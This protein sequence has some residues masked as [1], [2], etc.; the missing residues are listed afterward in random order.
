LPLAIIAWLSPETPASPLIEALAPDA[1]HVVRGP[2]ARLR[3]AVSSLQ[4]DDVAILLL[5]DLLL[6]GTAA[7]ASI[8]AWRAAEPPVLP[9]L[10]G[11]RPALTEVAS[12]YRAGLF[13]AL[14]RTPE[15]EQWRE[16]AS[17]V[18]RYRER[19]RE[20]LA[21]QRQQEETTRTLRHH[22]QRLQ[23]QL[24]RTTADLAASHDRLEAVNAELS[25]HMDQLS[26]LY[27]FGRELSR[28]RN[29]D[30]TLERMLGNLA[31][32]VGAGGAALVLRPAPGAPFAPR[33]LYPA[34]D[35]VWHRALARLEERRRELPDQR[36]GM[37]VLRVARR[38]GEPPDMPVSALPLHHGGLPGPAGP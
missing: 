34:E 21:I 20:R 8:R 17:R 9:V 26:L 6:D 3:R 2:P 13:D 23:Q 18:R 29:W 35:P 15:P 4:G 1:P 24:Q 16:I 32:F 37:L 36:E 11:D 25:R 10:L 30:A 12:L 38:E 5:D 14:P 28:A 7:A 31:R 27:S 33:R 22:R 19:Y